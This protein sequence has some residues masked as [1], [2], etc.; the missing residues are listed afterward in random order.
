MSRGVQRGSR[1]GPEG[2]RRK[3]NR[4]QFSRTSGKIGNVVRSNRPSRAAPLRTDRGVTDYARLVITSSAP[5]TKDYRAAARGPCEALP[6]AEP[7]RRP[8]CGLPS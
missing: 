7:N 5:Y 3:E 4:K 1:G 6:S 8:V 2:V